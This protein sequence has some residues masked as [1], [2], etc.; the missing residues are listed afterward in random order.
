[1]QK[2]QNRK[3]ESKQNL[4]PTRLLL[5]PVLHIHLIHGRK[6][7]HVSQEDGDLDDVLDRRARRFEHGGEVADTLVLGVRG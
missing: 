4:R 1:M 6:V 3:Q 5:A 7:L 2:R